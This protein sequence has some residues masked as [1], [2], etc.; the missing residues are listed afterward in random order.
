MYK[1]S[2]YTNNVTPTT[3]NLIV[4]K[5]HVNIFNFF[6]TTFSIHHYFFLDWDLVLLHG[7]WFPCNIINWYFLIHPLWTYIRSREMGWNTLD[8]PSLFFR[9]LFNMSYSFEAYKT[10]LLLSNFIFKSL[11][12]NLCTCWHHFYS[13]I[14]LH[15]H[16]NPMALQLKKQM[17]QSRK[18]M[19]PLNFL[20][21]FHIL[22][23]QFTNNE[24]TRNCHHP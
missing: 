17:A 4:L 21:I 7:Q 2:N 14:F 6:W 9:P 11:S 18:S 13:Y 24:I 12:H 8:S 19:T 22:F 23:L 20:T 3:S 15:Y 1:T 10:T 5:M 16:R